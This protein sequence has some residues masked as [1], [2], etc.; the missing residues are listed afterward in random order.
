MEHY[1]LLGL[2]PPILTIVLAFITRDVIIS[3]FLGILS[4]TLIVSGGNPLL[5]LMSLTDRLADS[6][7]DGWNIRIFLFCG[8]LGALVGMLAKTGSAFSFGDWAA[9]KIKTKRESLVFTWIFGL[10]IFI[11]DYFNSLT[12]GTVMRPI[13][14]KTKTSRAKLAYILDSTA[15]PVCILAPISSWVVYVMSVIK[16]SEG[17]GELGIKEFSYFI[18]VIPFNIYALFAILMVIVIIFTAR[19]FGPMVNSCNLAEEENILFNAEKYGE[20][21]GNIE[22]ETG[23]KKTRPADMLFPI[24]FLIISAVVFFPVSTWLASIDGENIKSFKEAVAAIPLATAFNDTDASAALMYAVIATLSVSYIYYVAK[25]LLTIK[26]AASAILD[27]L[28]SMVPALMIL[29]MAW[30]IGSLIKSSPADGGLGLSA[31]LSESVVEGG[32]PLWLLPIVVFLISCLISFSTGTSWGTFAIMIPI[33]MPIAVA[34]GKA[35][36][37]EGADLLNATLVPIGAVLGGAIFGDHSSP[38]SD[39]TILSSTG[40]SCPHL[41]HV[42]TQVPYAVF[43]AVVALIGHI[44]AG[45]TLSAASALIAASVVFGIGILFLP[46]IF[47]GNA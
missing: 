11:D 4:G 32:F 18:H 42:A 9:K 25:K 17:F 7:A 39:T 28:K 43:I 22:Q 34:L 35:S 38:I 40:A 16:D 29:T 26:T 6:L 13:T 45:L 46:K 15:A 24:I 44:V 1:G 19:D 10:I 36:G 23:T 30:S 3:L 2:V 20:P 5:A 47:K 8:L 31:F 12:I 37:Y 27:G 14:D 33:I 21:A 41:E